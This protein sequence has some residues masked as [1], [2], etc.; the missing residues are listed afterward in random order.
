MWSI[1]QDLSPKGLVVWAS[2]KLCPGGTAIKHQALQT[3]AGEATLSLFS[4]EHSV[5]C[6]R[7]EVQSTYTLILTITHIHVSPHT[8]IHGHAAPLIVHT[9]V[10]APR[11][12]CLYSI[13]LFT[14]DTVPC[15]HENMLRTL[16]YTH[17]Y[18]AMHT[19]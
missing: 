7:I 8:S 11:C 10:L 9:E 19:L 14:H 12:T 4:Q 15:I 2:L 18:I 5:R 3:G 1:C 17:L 16:I 6:K 13:L